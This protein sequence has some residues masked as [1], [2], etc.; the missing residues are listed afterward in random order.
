MKRVLVE[1]ALAGEFEDEE[2]A[3]AVVE[4]AVQ[5]QDVGVAQVGLDL[6]LAADLLLH[7]ALLEL[8]FVQHFQ[9]ADEVCGALF[10]EVD[11]AEFA[12]AQGF[13]DL[14]HAEVEG[15]GRGELVVDC[16]WV[17]GVGMSLDGNFI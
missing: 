13:A 15:S 9:R 14:E 6:D 17:G 2:D 7:L 10:G 5:A 4:V 1:L 12:F 3:L 8:G 11:A 16:C